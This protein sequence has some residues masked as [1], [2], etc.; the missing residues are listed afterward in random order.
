MFDTQFQYPQALWLLAAVPF[1]ILLFVFYILWQRKAATRMGDPRLIKNLQKG[2]SSLKAVAKFCLLA[3]SFSA[4]CIAIANPRKAVPGGDEVRKG[5]DVA[6]VLDVSNSMLASDNVTGNRLNAA[7]EF[8]TRL[9]NTMPENRFAL[10]L[11]AGQAYVQMPLT[12]DHSATRL[13]LAA[14]SPGIITAQGTGINEALKK[15][16]PVFSTTLDRYKAIILITDGE[17]HDEGAVETAAGMASGGI[18]V[19]TVGIGSADGAA[20]IDTATRESKKDP[21]GNVIL[22]KLNEPLLQQIATAAKGI[23][24]NLKNSG[25][26]VNSLATEFSTVEKKALVDVSLLNYQT[27]YF[28]LAAPML[29]LLLI[30]TFFGDRK[31][32]GA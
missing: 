26:A 13:F 20:I 29:L 32:T 14:A 3:L 31:K 8:I 23:Y 30:E 16:E 9:V 21:A 12:Y 15:A 7:K 1:F 27:F 10:V 6:V 25:E 11:F 22:S 18:M 24:I 28:W 4:G 17:T 19:H 2:H 5:I